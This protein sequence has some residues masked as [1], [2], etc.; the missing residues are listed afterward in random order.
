MGEYDRTREQKA[1]EKYLGRKTRPAMGA[2]VLLGVLFGGGWLIQVGLLQLDIF[3]RRYSPDV[4]IAGNFPGG[5]PPA[6]LLVALLLVAT[7][8]GIDL[9]VQ[10]R[11]SLQIGKVLFWGFPS[12]VLSIEK[13]HLWYVYEA[14]LERESELE[15]KSNAV[16]ALEKELIEHY[17]DHGPIEDLRQK[18]PFSAWMISEIVPHYENNVEAF[19]YFGAGL[20]IVVVGLRGIGYLKADQAWAILISLFL[21]FTIITFLG[22]LR[23]FKPERS[24]LGVVFGKDGN[25]MEAIQSQVTELKSSIVEMRQH[26]DGVESRV[27]KLD[28]SVRSS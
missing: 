20:L 4:T 25:P 6:V 15:P 13:L 10:G 19:A 1:H 21:E 16:E 2:V 17:K 7:E 12:V 18:R 5:V 26:L 24:E 8:R 3:L 27:K 23:F 14:L 28:S 11:L 22:M 9:T